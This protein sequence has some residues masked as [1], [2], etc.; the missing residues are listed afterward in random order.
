LP[1]P[2]PLQAESRVIPHPV[3]FQPWLAMA[4]GA[5]LLLGCSS[6]TGGD[7]VSTGGAPGNQGTGGAGTGGFQ[8]TS[9]GGSTNIG[10]GGLAD[11]LG[12]GGGPGTGGAT[13]TGGVTETGGAVASGGKSGGAAGGVGGR[14]MGS[15][16]TGGMATMGNGGAGTGS[17]SGGSAPNNCNLP[18]PVSFKN[19]V[20]PILTASCGKNTSN[21]CHVVDGSS[22]LGSACPDGTKTCGA[23][24]AYDWITA[25]AH[26]SSCPE[27]PT[28]K[29]FE[30]TIAVIN[31]ANPPTCSKSRKMPPPGMGTA[32]TTCQVATL[33]AWID[34]PKV[35][36]LHRTDDS[37]P[38]TPYAMPPFN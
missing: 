3:S 26:A 28:P 22:T 2:L 33:Q 30:V 10:T 25:G 27:T 4:L 37:S 19:D 15:T 18:S 29:R 7:S 20:Q 17:G 34:E 1:S 5:G 14:A 35:T 36:Q 24:H 12:T 32:L 8:A 9:T 23:T 38:T 13:G 31:G 21:G 16:G 11:A 6:S